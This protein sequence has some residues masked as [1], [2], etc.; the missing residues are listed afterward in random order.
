MSRI[1]KRE[2]K[3]HLIA[4]RLVNKIADLTYLEKVF[5]LNN[6]HPG[7]TH[8]TGWDGIFFTPPELARD[9]S[10]EFLDNQNKRTIDLCAG[11]GALSFMALEKHKGWSGTFTGKAEFVC[12][13]QNAE[14]CKVGKKV[15]P[16]ATWICANVFDEK[17]Y[18]NL[19]HFDE[20]ISNPP[21][22]VSAKSDW[23]Q[24]GPSQFMVAEIAMKIASHGVFILDQH[25]VPFKFSGIQGFQKQECSKYKSWFKKTGI[26]FRMNCGIDTSLSA[27]N[28]RG[29]NNMVT[30]VVILD[31]EEDLRIQFEKAA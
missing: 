11:I 12:I 4:M 5:V 23:L 9:M 16:E 29:L 3:D 1:S 27:K 8:N 26:T 21:Y 24:K 6:Y 31:A 15:V 20:V 14:F 13:E 30:E 18:K 10:I 19:G 25:D 17:I 22:G 28:W 2:Y 7:A